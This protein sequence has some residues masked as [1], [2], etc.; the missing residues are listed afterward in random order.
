MNI[1]TLTFANDRAL[2]AARKAAESLGLPM[3]ELA[4]KPDV[5]ALRVSAASQEGEKITG[6][7]MRTEVHVRFQRRIGGV[8]VAFSRV[9]AA[10][11]ARGDIARMHVRWPDFRLVRGL[12]AADATPREAIVAR[13]LDDVDR[14][15]RCGSL[16][17]IVSNVVYARTADVEGGE[18]AGADDGAEKDS[19][20]SEFVPALMV[21]VIPVV[22]K[23]DSGVPQ[24]PV[25][26]YV[27]PLLRN[28]DRADRR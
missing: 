21:T 27:F 14:D 17:R 16:S 26:N 24:M 5:R 28:G 7:S 8:P 3:R 19:G 9:H 15:N 18:G 23:D 20:P 1:R 4:D 10:V 13:V 12:K 11:D 25:Q 2:T 6:Q 22:Q